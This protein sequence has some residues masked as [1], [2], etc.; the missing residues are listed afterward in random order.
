MK[1]KIDIIS[2][3]TIFYLKEL[4]VILKNNWSK[5]Q[6]ND[7]DIKLKNSFKNK[8]K[9]ILKYIDAEV[10]SNKTIKESELAFWIEIYN[11]AIESK[12]NI[13]LNKIKSI[14]KINR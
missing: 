4:R 13:I 7:I 12:E 3:F 2:T 8:S 10:K 9:K 5:T 14:F 1:N 11:N 6:A